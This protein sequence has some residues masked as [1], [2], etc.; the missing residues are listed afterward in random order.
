MASARGDVAMSVYASLTEALVMLKT[1]K[2]TSE[3]IHNCLAQ[4]SK[5]QFD[6]QAKIPELELLS[7]LLDVT[8]G[9][10]RDTHEVL[11]GRLHELKKRIGTSG[12]SQN[13]ELLIPIKRPSSGAQTVSSETSAIIRPGNTQDPDQDHL[14]TKFMTEQQMAII[15]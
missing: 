3:A 14:V 7:L 8:V 12:V 10:N 11:D 4:A 9:F 6:E 2:A 1:S 5:H 15:V 13:G